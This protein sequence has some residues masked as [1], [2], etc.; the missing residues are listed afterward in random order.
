MNKQQI[1]IINKAH[2]SEGENVI[3]THSLIARISELSQ[4]ADFWNAWMLG[5]L[6][7]AFIA[8]GSVAFTTRM[9]IVRA[10]QL[11]EAQDELISAKDRQ[12]VLDLKDKDSKIAE[13]N[14]R[15][16][17]ADEITERERLAR[18]RIEA[19]LAWRTISPEQSKELEKI[20]ATNQ[21]SVNIE[22]LFNDP[23]SQYFSEQLASIFMKAKW[24]VGLTGLNGVFPGE[25]IFGL[26]VPDPSSSLVFF[27]R[28]AFI[29]A[30]LAFDTTTIPPFTGSSTGVTITGAPIIFV[31]VKRQ[32]ISFK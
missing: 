17:E 1:A 18:L 21:N 23:E 20:L 9:S 30:K 19:E 15:A 6:V 4:S 12:L 24:K 14:A 11:A 2:I 22:Y 31:G 29:S 3:D 8:A 27:I 13:A 16:K 28:N 32:S 26:R 5:T 7:F 10:K 25:L